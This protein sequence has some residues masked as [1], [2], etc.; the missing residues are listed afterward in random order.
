MSVRGSRVWPVAGR[1]V[2]RV[3]SQPRRVDAVRQ[4]EAEHHRRQVD[5]GADAQHPGGAALAAA[6]DDINACRCAGPEGRC[7]Q[8]GKRGPGVGR[9]QRDLR[10]Q[11]PGRDRAPGDA[12][13]LLQHEDPEG[14]GQQGDRVVVLHGPGHSPAEQPASEQ[15]ARQDEPPSLLHL[16]QHRADKR[17]EHGERRHGDQQR[18]RYPGAGLVDRGAEEQGARQRHRDERV[19]EAARRRK[20]DEIREPGTPGAGRAG[21]PVHGPARAAR[22]GGASASGCL[23]GGYHRAGSPPGSRGG[24]GLSHSP[25]ILLS[26]DCDDPVRQ[27]GCPQ[28]RV[29]DARTP[30]D[31]EQSLIVSPTRTRTREPDEACAPAVDLARAAAQEMAGTGQVGSYRGVEVDA[32]RVVTHLFDCLD[33]AYT[34]WRWAVTVARASR[35]KLVTVSESVVLPG[36]DSLLAPDW[37]PWRDRVRPGDVGVGDLLPAGQDDERLVP[38]VVLEGDDGVLD[39][40]DSADWAAGQDLLAAMNLTDAVGT[41]SV[42]TES[43]GTEPAA[44]AGIRSASADPA[45]ADPASADPASP[46]PASPEQASPEQASPEQASPESASV[47]RA[48][49]VAAD[50]A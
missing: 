48:G 31:Q 22:G 30:A 42:G 41:E 35:A 28:S 27:A 18:Q 5:R 9:D 3:A 12:E 26:K 10:R 4:P 39:W 16:V 21:E 43:V 45:S 47:E 23:R 17:G 32:D 8:R 50:A 29:M 11:Q 40:D 44:A 24:A 38:A 49:A 37:V 46:D 33:P 14:S 13:G 19:A 6:E 36:P 20:L 15:R 25:S 7:D 34:G 1:A 2:R